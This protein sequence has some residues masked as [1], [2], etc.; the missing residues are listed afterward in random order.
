MQTKETLW[1]IPRRRIRFVF[2]SL[3]FL[4]GIL[5]LCR[6]ATYK[7]GIFQKPEISRRFKFAAI[8]KTHPCDAHN[9]TLGFGSIQVIN[10]PHRFDRY[11]SITMQAEITGLDIT[12]SDGVYG[13]DVKKSILPPTTNLNENEIACIRA[14]AITWRRMLHEGLATS[15]I[16]ESDADWEISIKSSMALIMQNFSRIVRSGRGIKDVTRLPRKSDHFQE[17][18][19]DVL[20]LGVCQ[21]LPNH[22]ERDRISFPDPQAPRFDQLDGGQKNILSQYFG[23]NNQ[24]FGSQLSGGSVHFPR[25]IQ[26]SNGSICTTAYAVSRT[27]AMKLLHQTSRFLDDAVDVIMQ[28]M[29]SRGLLNMYTVVPP[30]AGQWKYI[31]DDDANSDIGRHSWQDR[32]IAE[33]DAANTHAGQALAQKTTP[34]SVDYRVFDQTWVSPPNV[35]R[36]ALQAVAADLWPGSSSH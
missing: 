14:H 11:D 1:R 9:R 24:A 16:M 28:R 13:A 34:R 6:D 22:L 29:A 12:F 32:Q 33:E 20:Q 4:A 31:D 10:M 23:R 5:T 25:I 27:G 30:L 18:N 15:L 3:V 36:S 17:D 8:A 2:S 26:R 7:I 35:A 21:E 19:W